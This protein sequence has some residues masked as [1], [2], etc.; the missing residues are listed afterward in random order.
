MQY[1]F[2]R[3]TYYYSAVFTGALIFTPFP[4]AQAG[5]KTAT[6]LETNVSEFGSTAEVLV[7]GNKVNGKRL[8]LNCYARVLVNNETRLIEGRKSQA[9]PAGG[10][11]S[12]AESE[13]TPCSK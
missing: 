3:N 2:I 10:T 9:K 4:C 1:C 6:L 11:R 5:D 7:D 8:G 13:T 12:L